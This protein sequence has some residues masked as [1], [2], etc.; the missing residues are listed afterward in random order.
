[1]IRFSHSVFALPFAY[2]SMILAGDFAQVTLMK[3]L[4]IT[5][6][7]VGARSA[8]MGFNRLIDRE[9]D[10]RNPRT[11]ERAL[12]AG[13]ISRGSTVTFITLASVVFF[14][15]AWMLN[16]LAFILSPI[17][18]AL[19]TG[20]SYTKRFT[21]LSHLI[22]GLS[23]AV[24]PVGAWIGVTG[25]FH[26]VPLIIA[27][28]VM[29]WTAGFDVIYSF[30]DVEYDREHGLYSIP[31]NMP[32]AQARLIAVIFHLLSLLLFGI[33]AVYVHD[34]R[35]YIAYIVIIMMVVAQHIILDVNDYKSI[36]RAFF[37][38]NSVISVVFLAGI[39]L[40]KWHL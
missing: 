10:R 3:L 19:I 37:Y 16:M 20:Y 5:T 4:W 24:A 35:F 7:M 31:A 14:F 15:S 26:I 33:I 29:F 6:A 9:I 34:I 18:L 38:G 36:N 11:A 21:N 25:S 2:S 39:F 30:Q 40:S 8:A 32:E 28:G 17:A 22:L 1:M 27:G 12:P 23:L 13:R